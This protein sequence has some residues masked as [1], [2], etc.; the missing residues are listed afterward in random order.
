MEGAIARIKR[1]T[2]DI[3][4][5]LVRQLQFIDGLEAKV[6]CLNDDVQKKNAFLKKRLS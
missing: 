2:T 4:S 3:N 6:S 5:E 1:L